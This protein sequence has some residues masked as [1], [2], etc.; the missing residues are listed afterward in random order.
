[1]HDKTEMTDT[2]W[3]SKLTPEQY[4]VTREQGTE[5][6]FTGVYYDCATSGTYHCVC[7][8]AELFTSTAKFDSGSGWPSF[9]EAAADGSVQLRED[10]SHGMQRTE[11]TCTACGAHLGHV[12]PDGP[13]PTGQRFCINSAALQLEPDA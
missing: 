4:H 11:A 9:Y 2:D 6:P 10:T 12:F 7:C 8:N 13:F 5:A 3:K 1:M